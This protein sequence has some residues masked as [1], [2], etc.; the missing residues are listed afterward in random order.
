[1]STIYDDEWALNY[2]RRANA[3]IPGREGL[4]RLCVACLTDLPAAARVLVVGAGT[5]DELLLL[6]QAKPGA[7]FVAL[8]PADAMRQ[9]CAARLEAAGLTS[10]VALVPH[11]LADYRRN[12]GVHGEQSTDGGFDAATAIL[13]SQHIPHSEQAAA[14][15]Q[16]LYLQ[17]RPGGRLFSA[18]L[19]IAQGQ[20]RIAMLGLWQVQARLAGVEPDLLDR[21]RVAF[22]H[23][24]RPRDEHQILGFL[25]MA[26]FVDVLKPFSS[27]IYGAWTARRTG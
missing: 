2:V 7:S 6:A 20:D 5:G 3:S 24:P 9:H 4:Y 14:F 11:L 10:R 15:F 12:A 25:Q 16:D 21:M 26:G 13:V 18:D 17:L 27:L 23:D 1:M 8:E 22:E 19:H